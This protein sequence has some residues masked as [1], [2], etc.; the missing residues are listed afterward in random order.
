MANSEPEISPTLVTR[1]EFA[2]LLAELLTS[3]PLTI[4]TFRLQSVTKPRPVLCGVNVMDS[5]SSIR[6]KRLFAIFTR[7]HEAF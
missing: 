3:Q 1:L 7:F 4:R 5:R 2:K 6:S